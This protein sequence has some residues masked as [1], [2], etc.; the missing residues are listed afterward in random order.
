MQRLILVFTLAA[1]AAAA[2]VPWLTVAGNPQDPKADTIQINPVAVSDNGRTRL[3]ELRIS[4]SHER[5]S[6]D[7]VRFRSFHAFVEFNCEA[8]TA[9]FVRSQFFH[10]PLW[11]APGPELSYPADRVRSMDFRRFDPNPRDRVIRAA[12]HPR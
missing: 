9:R 7:Q 2:Q 5:T 3:M 11:I 6:Q 12:C 10:E 1:G 4:R 8:M